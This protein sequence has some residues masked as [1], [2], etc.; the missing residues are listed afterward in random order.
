MTQY[1]NVETHNLAGTP[2]I[3]KPRRYLIRMVIF[4]GI[5][6]A[7]AAFLYPQ[8][9][10]AFLANPWLNGLIIVV[11]LFGILFIFRQVVMLY[12]EINWTQSLRRLESTRPTV[13]PPRL[14]APLFTIFNDSRGPVRLNAVTMNSLLDS[15]GARMEEGRDISRYLINVLI[16]LGLLGTFW[17]LLETVDSVGGA[18]AALNVGGGDRKSVV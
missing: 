8:I 14:L 11:L 7:I 18:I 17:G 3:K 15:V 4:I 1:T 16:F 5:A 12:G 9:Q 2:N 6:I 10:T 13:Q